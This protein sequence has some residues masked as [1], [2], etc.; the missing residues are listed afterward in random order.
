MGRL[1][2][3]ASACQLQSAPSWLFSHHYTVMAK[4]LLAILAVPSV[5]DGLFM[6]LILSPAI[7]VAEYE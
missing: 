3:L 1:V 2:T 7:Q 4:L 6:G 5:L